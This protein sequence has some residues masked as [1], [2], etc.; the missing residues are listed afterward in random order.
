M[1]IWV[2]APRE[3]GV[4]HLPRVGGYAVILAV[5]QCRTHEPI[6]LGGYDALLPTTKRSAQPPGFEVGHLEFA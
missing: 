2:R 6:I 3:V 1:R 4:D 5:E